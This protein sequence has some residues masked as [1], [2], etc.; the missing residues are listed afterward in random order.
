MAL[1]AMLATL[2]REIVKDLEDVEGDRASFMR[3]VASGLRKAVGERFRVRGGKVTLS[4]SRSFA[5]AAAVLCLLAAVAISLIPY[6]WGIL[7]E[8]YMTVVAVTDI[9]FI[10]ASLQLATKKHYGSVSRQIKYGMAIGMA[11]FF[12]GIL[13]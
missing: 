7:G 11:A 2:A 9:I 5:I 10:R 4:Y 1:L 8:S 6:A 13:I 12:T 3:R